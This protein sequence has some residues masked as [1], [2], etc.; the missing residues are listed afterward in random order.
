[1]TD[2]FSDLMDTGF[3]DQDEPD[4]EAPVT[5]GLVVSV[6]AERGEDLNTE[7]QFY[8]AEKPGESPFVI[9]TE[10]DDDGNEVFENA[11]DFIE[12]MG[13]SR[14]PTEAEAIRWSNLLC[15]ARLAQ[16]GWDGS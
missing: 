16:M 6:K 3:V 1:M 8:M 11:K 5:L 9:F 7:E 14:L 2:I 12:P 10:T 13:M 15:G 4:P